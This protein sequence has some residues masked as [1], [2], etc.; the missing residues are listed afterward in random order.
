MSYIIARARCGLLITKDLNIYWEELHALDCIISYHP[1][2]SLILSP[3]CDSQ[4][5]EIYATTLVALSRPTRLR[6]HHP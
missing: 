1:M 3:P 6:Y 2:S 5:S 4:Q